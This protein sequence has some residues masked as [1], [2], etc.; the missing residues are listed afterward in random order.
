MS[1]FIGFFKEC[2]LYEKISLVL[3]IAFTL[4]ATTLCVW[5]LIT[6]S[7]IWLL[8]AFMLLV[9]MFEAFVIGMILIVLIF[10]MNALAKWITKHFDVNTKE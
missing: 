10:L 8:R 9:L 5:V 1:D 6:G 2:K 4:L 7:T 3:Y